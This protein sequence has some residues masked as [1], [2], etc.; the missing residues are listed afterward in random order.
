MIALIEVVWRA[1]PVLV[2]PLCLNPSQIARPTLLHLSLLRQL[3]ESLAY[4]L[5]LLGVLAR[6]LVKKRLSL[7]KISLR[8]PVLSRT[9]EE[10]AAQIVARPCSRIS[11]NA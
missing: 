6:G 5:A 7:A 1:G 4:V 9:L 2:T 11:L 10:K 8:R 3:C